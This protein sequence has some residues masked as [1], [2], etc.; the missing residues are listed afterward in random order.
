MEIK[1]IRKA[2]TGVI[3]FLVIVLLFSCPEILLYLIFLLISLILFAIGFLII[4][5]IVFPYRIF[6]KSFFRDND[7]VKD[8]R[9]QAKGIIKTEDFDS[10]ILGTSMAENFSPEEASRIFGGK[11]VNISIYSGS[12]VEQISSAS[13]CMQEKKTF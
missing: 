12:M 11:F 2:F 4:S 5:W 13:I 7:Y 1:Q 8:L 10:I 6:H 9:I 3:S